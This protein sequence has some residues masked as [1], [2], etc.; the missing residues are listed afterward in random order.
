MFG[1][2]ILMLFNTACLCSF[3]DLVQYSSALVE[4]LV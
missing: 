3:D 1:C 4:G 2:S